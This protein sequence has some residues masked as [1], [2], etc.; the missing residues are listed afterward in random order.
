MYRPRPGSRWVKVGGTLCEDTPEYRAMLRDE[1]RRLRREWWV[2]F[3]G[4]LRAAFG[5]T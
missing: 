2:R 4:R 1:R 3:W 5:R